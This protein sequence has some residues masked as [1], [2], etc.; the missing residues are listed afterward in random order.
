MDRGVYLR[1]S[2]EYLQQLII[3]RL[4]TLPEVTILAEQLM[5]IAFKDNATV[6]VHSNSFQDLWISLLLELD[7]LAIEKSFKKE[8]VQ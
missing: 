1:Y 7:K 2:L 3:K 8:A 4:G 5:V 6:R